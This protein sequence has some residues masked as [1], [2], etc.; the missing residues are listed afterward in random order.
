MIDLSSSIPGFARFAC[1]DRSVGTVLFGALLG[2]LQ[3]RFV[4]VVLVVIWGTVLTVA[5]VG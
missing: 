2:E 3:L 1:F 5:A 4:S